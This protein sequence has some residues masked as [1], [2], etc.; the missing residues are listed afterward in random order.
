MGFSDA[1]LCFLLFRMIGFS[2]NRLLIGFLH[3]SAFLG[4]LFR[5]FEY[6]V[7]SNDWLPI[8]FFGSCFPISFSPVSLR[9]PVLLPPFCMSR[10]LMASA[11]K[12]NFLCHWGE[13]IR[14][15]VHS[16]LL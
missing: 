10:A 6:L 12:Q 11:Q 8:G 3:F 9:C 5:F 15:K 7:F 1:L 13:S 4:Q 2:A 16:D 14:V